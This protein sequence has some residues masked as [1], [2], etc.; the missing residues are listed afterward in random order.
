VTAQ[1]WMR[2]GRAAATYSWKD[3]V[4][5]LVGEMCVAIRAG[6]SARGTVSRGYA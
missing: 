6:E 2:G 5:L 3:M 1:G 4:V